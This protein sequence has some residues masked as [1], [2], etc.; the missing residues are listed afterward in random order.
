MNTQQNIYVNLRL[1][2]DQNT[3]QILLHTSFDRNA[4]NFVIFKNVVSWSPTVEELDFITES[5]SMVGNK[6]DK[7]TQATQN[8]FVELHVERDTTSKKLKL[9]IYFDTTALNFFHDEQQI[10]WSPTA[11]ELEF[12]N[13]ALALFVDD[14]DELFKPEIQTTMD[15]TKQDLQTSEKE[16]KTELIKLSDIPH[17]SNVRVINQGDSVVDKLISRRKR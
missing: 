17:N 15:E 5:F 4:P 14:Q 2:K 12:I 6:K 8:I 7:L 16:D 3:G 10:S 11:E 1:K 9:H 13:E